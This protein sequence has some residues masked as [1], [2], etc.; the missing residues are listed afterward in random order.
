MAAKALILSQNDQYHRLEELGSEIV[1]WTRG[2]HDLV[3]EVRHDKEILRDG[4]LDPYD[5]CIICATMD[6]ITAE[7]EQGIVDFVKKGRR[8]LGIHSATVVH[9]SRTA[10]IN[11]IGGRFTHHSH[12]HEF[13]VR[14]E[15]KDH[16][17]TEGIKDFKI[18]DELYVLDRTPNKALVLATA[19]W[20][21][22]EQPLLYLKTEGK[23]R[24]LYNALGHDQA[25]F[26]ALP[27]QRLVIQGISWLAGI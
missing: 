25:A 8:L 18:V 1:I 15:E 24:V 5:V 10:Y 22:R 20:E 11:L 21:G 3:T 14:I 19:S 23:G 26:N 27:F 4:G 17:I 13:K 2:L 16:P 12:Y 7:Q 6:D 9:E